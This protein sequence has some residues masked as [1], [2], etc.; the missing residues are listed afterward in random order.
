V[1]EKDFD[2]PFIADLALRDRSNVVKRMASL[3][4]AAGLRKLEA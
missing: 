2:V 4:E 3:Q 1:I